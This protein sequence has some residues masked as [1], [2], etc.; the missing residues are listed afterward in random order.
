M[1]KPDQSEIIKLAASVYNL[2]KAKDIPN[3]LSEKYKL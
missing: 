3:L 2:S 1:Q